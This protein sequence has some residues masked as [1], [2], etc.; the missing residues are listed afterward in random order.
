MQQSMQNLQA[1]QEIE[2]KQLLRPTC[3]HVRTALSVAPP[4]ANAA[5]LAGLSL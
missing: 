2:I 1:K 3:I 5:V 4:P